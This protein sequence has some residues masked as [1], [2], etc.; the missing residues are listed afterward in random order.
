MT[1][2]STSRHPLEIR[3][4]AQG[5][6]KQ[7]YKSPQ[8]KLPPSTLSKEETKYLQAGEIYGRPLTY[9][10][11]PAPDS[12][13]DPAHEAG[14]H[15]FNSPHHRDAL[16]AFQTSTGT[17]PSDASGC[18]DS[19]TGRW[20]GDVLHELDGPFC[21]DRRTQ[22]S[23][24]SLLA[25]HGHTN[26]VGAAGPRGSDVDAQEVRS[27]LLAARTNGHKARTVISTLDSHEPA[28]VGIPDSFPYPIPSSVVR[29]LESA[30][31]D[32]TTRDAATAVSRWFDIDLTARDTEERTD[33]LDEV[34]RRREG[35]RDYHHWVTVD[36]PECEGIME[37]YWAP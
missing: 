19:D 6:L 5:R 30:K 32:T 4:T 13:Y 22:A 26:R 2:P 12:L 36:G 28:T 37:G 1:K 23:L 18:T 15:W 31:R 34:A 7:L 16:V 20:S 24:T 8:P 25:Y 27:W 21:P 11:H 9:P 35:A 10:I 29:F 14:S 3:K 33:H 17:L